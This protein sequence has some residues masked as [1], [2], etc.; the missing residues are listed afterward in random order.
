MSSSTRGWRATFVW[1]HSL[2]AAGIC[3]KGNVSWAHICHPDCLRKTSVHLGE[4]QQRCSA[5]ISFFVLSPQISPKEN[6]PPSFICPGSCAHLP[7]GGSALSCS[8]V[9][10]C[11]S[12]QMITTPI[13]MS[14][15]TWTGSPEISNLGLLGHQ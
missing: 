4:M 8:L 14:L 3:Y 13:V 7:P 11:S 6:S 15:A 9:S 2:G 5:G 10:R 12:L 1:G